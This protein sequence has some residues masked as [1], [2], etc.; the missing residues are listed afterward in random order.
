MVNSSDQFHQ[1]SRKGNAA[2]RILILLIVVPTVCIALCF[3]VGYYGIQ[4]LFN[5]GFKPLVKKIDV[6]LYHRN[7]VKR[8]DKFEFTQEER[9]AAIAELDRIK[10]ALHKDVEERRPIKKPSMGVIFPTHET[11]AIHVRTIRDKYVPASN[12]SVN[13]KIAAAK[14]CDR[15]ICVLVSK[16]ISAEEIRHKLLNETYA[17][18]R[19]VEP[20]PDDGQNNS[21]V[22][23]DETELDEDWPP[24]PE[25]PQDVVSSDDHLR[26]LLIL[27]RTKAAKHDT[28]DV[29]CEINY[30]EQ[31]HKN[32][33]AILNQ[34]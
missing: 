7:S 21:P 6:D 31:I 15:L 8:L 12:L 4:Y 11:T 9:L 19:M 26:Q 27:F 3:G 30:V 28:A 14:I 29:P 23:S 5:E 10:D 32:V 18:F 1:I 22:G 2:I 34:L 24:P 20:E 17:F 25:M 33:D 13:D 16:A